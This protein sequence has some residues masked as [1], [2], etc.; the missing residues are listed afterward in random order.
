LTVNE[1][2]QLDAKG[3]E[4]LLK[5]LDKMA[6]SGR[7][8]E[9]EAAQ[10]HAASDST[11]FDQAARDIRVRHAREHLNA[12]VEGGQ[13]TQQEAHSHLE[14]LKRGGHSRSLRAHLRSLL[15]GR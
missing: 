7:I 5:Q 4:R 15:P 11:E 1:D 9:T 13:M 3:R 10:L 2:H 8:T 14:G 6:A 12:A